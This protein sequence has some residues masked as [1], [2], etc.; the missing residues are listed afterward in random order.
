MHL[1]VDGE[2]ER[3]GVVIGAAVDIIW[4]ICLSG[5]GVYEILPGFIAG[6]IVAIVVTRITPAPGKEVTDIFDTAIAEGEHESE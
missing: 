1:L 2:I 3:A 5:T 4:L 6:G